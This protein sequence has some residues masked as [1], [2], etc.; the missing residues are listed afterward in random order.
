MYIGA[1]RVGD[2]REVAERQ[3]QPVR[4]GDRVL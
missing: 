2:L 1:G 4:D 3:E